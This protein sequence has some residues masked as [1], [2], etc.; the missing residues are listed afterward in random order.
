[1]SQRAFYSIDEDV[2]EEFNRLVPS[3]KRSKLVQNL[4]MKYV[5]Q[6]DSAIERA[7]RLIESDA[8]YSDVMADSASIGTATLKRIDPDE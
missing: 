4:M 3:A 1:M 5:S 2:L 8:S 6:N 7:A